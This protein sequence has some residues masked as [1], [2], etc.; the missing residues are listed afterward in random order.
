MGLTDAQKSAVRFRLGWSE[1]FFQFDSRLEQAMSAL[2]TKPEAVALVTNPLGGSPPGLL[3][4]IDDVDARIVDSFKRVRAS[5]VANVELNPREVAQLRDLGRM[6]VKRLASLLGVEV[7]ED[8]FSPSPTRGFAGWNGPYPG[9]G[10][11]SFV[12]K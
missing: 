9:A 10:G 12:G 3:A 4:Q 2:D 6:Y 8:C 11:G 7:R 1:R 5:K